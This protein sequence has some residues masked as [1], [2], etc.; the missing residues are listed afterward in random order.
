MKEKAE[1]VQ[2]VPNRGVGGV[3]KACL[4]TSPLSSRKKSGR[5][6]MEGTGEDRGRTKPTQLEG[7]TGT[8]GLEF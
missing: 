4:A 7:G 8:V 6:L 5:E 2:T 1:R 3:D